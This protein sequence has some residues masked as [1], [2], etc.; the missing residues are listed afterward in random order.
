MRS[1]HYEMSFIWEARFGNEVMF[2][3]V[4]LGDGKISQTKVFII[5]TQFEFSSGIAYHLQ[6]YVAYLVLRVSNE[7]LWPNRFVLTIYE[8]YTSSRFRFS[9]EYFLMWLIKFNSSS[10]VW[11]QVGKWASTRNVYAL[12]K[13][14]RRKHLRNWIVFTYSYTLH[15]LKPYGIVFL[16]MR[17]F[18]ASID[19]SATTQRY[20]LFESTV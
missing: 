5:Y 8:L 3:D 19:T 12:C 14:P 15:R 9:L 20:D 17:D 16:S 10:S 18:K 11:T 2:L 6:C 7:F 13:C 1:L 4:V